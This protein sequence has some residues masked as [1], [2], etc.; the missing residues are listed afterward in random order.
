MTR[1]LYRSCTCT[2]VQRRVSTCS[3]AP[4]CLTLRIW[5]WASGMM[6]RRR[7]VRETS[8][9][10]SL[11]A[12]WVRLFYSLIQSVEYY[13][14]SIHNIIKYSGCCWIH[15]W[16]QLFPVTQGTGVVHNYVSCVMQGYKAKWE[17]C[18]HDWFIFWSVSS[19]F[20]CALLIYLSNSITE[21]I[22]YLN[23]VSWII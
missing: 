6:G 1:Q 9:L 22:I 17:E 23:L 21:K 14:D 3:T 11:P 19:R 4:C 8:L 12:W 16:V 10:T 7:T 18:V 20:N 5:R 2:P 15:S 13:M